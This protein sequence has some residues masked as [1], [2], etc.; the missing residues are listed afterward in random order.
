MLAT[1]TP[2]PGRLPGTTGGPPARRGQWLY[3]VKWDGMRVLADIDERGLHLISRNERDVTVAFPEL[4]GL[5]QLQDALL[6]GEVVALDERGVPSFA[7][8]A[9]RLHVTD[10]RK[11]AAASR[12]V[13]V[14]FMVFDVLRL[15]GVDL[16]S[17]PLS[18]RR[19]TLER[20][21][22]PTSVQLSPVFTDG[23][24][25]LAATRDQGVEGVVAKRVDSLYYPGRRSRDWVKAPHRQRRT[26]VVGG[27]RPQTDTVNVV[28]SL[29]VGAPDRDGGLRY[30]GRV[31]AGVGP[32]AN[33]LLSPLLK[34]LRQN[35][36]PFRDAVPKADATGA[37]WV[38]PQVLVDVEHLGFAGQGRLRQPAYCGVRT[39]SDADPFPDA[40]AVT[41]Q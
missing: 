3:E 37:T 26:V 21:D 1:P 23:D 30:L 31:G 8:L 32:A 34:P 19:A 6:D 17:R 9:E 15:Y 13:P 2:V 38:D 41:S 24:A 7:V 35:A 27:W 39:D 40:E 25:L 5:T 20:L 18:E 36:S 12:S 16:T 14:T 33:R 28:G 22:L 29:L 10:R 11:A 4:A